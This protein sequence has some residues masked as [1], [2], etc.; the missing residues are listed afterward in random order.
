M[1]NRRFVLEIANDPDVL[2]RVV[3]LCR[4]RRCELIAVSYLAGDRHRPGEL[5]LSVRAPA[6]YAERLDDWLAALIPVFVVHDLEAPGR[7]S[8]S[9]RSCESRARAA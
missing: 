5:Q 1:L 4:R 9:P 2:P 7:P 6:W 3:A 8:P